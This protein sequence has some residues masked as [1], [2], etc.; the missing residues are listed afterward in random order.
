MK[1]KGYVFDRFKLNQQMAQI[2]FNEKN[3]QPSIADAP[4]SVLFVL[5]AQYTNTPISI[6]IYNRA[7]NEGPEYFP[8]EIEYR[9][10]WESIP[11]EVKDAYYSE[12]C[13]SL[14]GFVD[15]DM[16]IELKNWPG[17]IGATDEDWRIRNEYYNSDQY[18]LKWRDH[19]QSKAD[20]Y[21]RYFNKYGLSKT[22]ND[23][24]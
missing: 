4:N 1:K 24:L 18:K 6:D 15:E 5:A 17:I 21:N 14:W 22:I 16:P 12:P 11:T 13:N 23:F 2:K 9:N 20:T 8:E 10:K 3:K 19:A 7:L